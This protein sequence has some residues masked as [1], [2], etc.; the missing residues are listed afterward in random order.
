MLQLSKKRG[1]NRIDLITGIAT[2]VGR[3]IGQQQY[4][5]TKLNNKLILCDTAVVKKL[6]EEKKAL[7]QEAAFNKRLIAKY[8]KHFQI[9]KQL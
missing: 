5:I 6:L 3:F 1:K 4:E 9:Y 7:E 2:Q 8:K